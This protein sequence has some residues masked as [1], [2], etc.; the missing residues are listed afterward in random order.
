MER[1]KTE[2]TRCTTDVPSLTETATGPQ[3]SAT[4]GNFGRQVRPRHSRCRRRHTGDYGSEHSTE[5]TGRRMAARA[6]VRDPAVPGSSTTERRHTPPSPRVAAPTGTAEGSAPPLPTP[7][8]AADRSSPARDRS[9]RPRLGPRRHGSLHRIGERPS[10]NSSRRVCR[11]CGWTG[12]VERREAGVRPCGG[13]GRGP[14]LS[15]HCSMSIP[16]TS[17]HR[18]AP[19]LLARGWPHRRLLAVDPSSD[20]GSRTSLGCAGVWAEELGEVR[21][22][23]RRAEEESLSVVAPERNEGFEFVRLLYA[24]R[25]D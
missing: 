8:T 2:T 21:A 13:E 25:G 11:C 15:R 22:R 16:V 5:L 14:R 17:P 23:H 4:S 3:S 7:K 18:L 20:P 10:R 12:L 9:A 19:L 6:A 1:L 24:L